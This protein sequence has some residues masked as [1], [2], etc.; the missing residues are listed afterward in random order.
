MK[1]LHIRD[2]PET[3][4][5]RLKLRAEWNHR[6]LQGELHHVLTEAANVPLPDDNLALNLKMVRGKGRKNWSRTA[7]YED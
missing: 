4:L 2:L 6:S 3:L 7:L 5:A 1:S